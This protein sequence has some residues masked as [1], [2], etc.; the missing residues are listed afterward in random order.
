MTHDWLLGTWRLLRADPSL[1]F[2]PGVRMEFRMDGELYYHVDVGGRDQ[3]IQLL[4]RIDG[5]LLH[6]DNPATPHSMSVR[7]TH[8]PGDT[9]LLD[10]GGPQAL[11]LREF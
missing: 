3:V 2:A 11:L 4:Y 7:L 1:D 10:F 8:G 6:T 5:D 9:L